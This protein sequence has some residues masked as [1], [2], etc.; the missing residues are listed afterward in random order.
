M[1]ILDRS[2]RAK[3]SALRLIRALGGFEI[4]RRLTR[5]Q[6][7]ILCFHAG[8]VVDEHIFSPGLFTSPATFARRMRILFRM[9]LPVV[10]LSEALDRLDSG[11]IDAGQTVITFDDGW[12]TT[13]DQLVPIARRYG[14]PVTVY[15]TTGSAEQGA[16]VF[17]V[18]LGYLLWAADVDVLTITGW[19]GVDGTYDLGAPAPASYDLTPPRAELLRCIL[20]HVESADLDGDT[21]QRL[22]RE[23][24]AA[25]QLDTRLILNGY[26]FCI[27]SPEELR[28]ASRAGV[29]LQLHTH[30]HR[31]LRNREE[32]AKEVTTNRERLHA[33]T[34]IR[35]EHFCYPSGEVAPGQPGWLDELGVRSSTTTR[36]DFNSSRTPRQ[37]L[38]RYLDLE[39]SDDLEFEAELAGVLEILRRL[40]AI[41]RRPSRA[42]GLDR[43]VDLPA[44]P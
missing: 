13:F 33:W 27:A 8:S 1:D 5:H 6:L 26:R 15:V 25:L 42:A 39:L 14:F 22:L 18:T 44:N 19:P 7:R 34:G 40:R 23:L 36:H 35:P 38:N 29:D 11:N 24:A 32:F 12:K 20:R 9:G 10:S 17:P 21:R 41:I 31:S 4:A 16:E 37:L 3:V 43:V 30:S 2:R 28:N